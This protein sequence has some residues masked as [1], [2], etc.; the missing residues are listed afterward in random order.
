MDLWKYFD[1]THR[2][3][4]VCNPTSIGKLEQLVTLLN[5]PPKAQVLEFASGKA[6]FL[7][8]LAEQYDIVG[9]GIDLSPYCIADAKSKHRERIP[10]AQLSFLEMDGADYQPEKPESFDLV[11]CIGA[12]WIFGGH[13]GTVKAL[14]EMTVP[15][16]LI[17]VGE[18]YWRQEP[19]AD[20]LAAI[21]EKR[22]SYGTHFENVAVAE[23]RGLKLLYTLVSNQ[24]DWDRYEGLQ[25][26]AS[27]EWASLSPE[28]P[29]VK[30]LLKRV[31]KN[32]EVYLKWERETLGWAIY[33]FKKV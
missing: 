10:D 20:Y 22:D 21:D 4:V 16:G 28:D 12:S 2:K 15:G 18:P 17:I 3:H 9:T 27:E 33:V 6:E 29:D 31:Y 19:E 30:E 5:L 32:K 23:K 25:W 7:V 8:R 24:D 14:R 26:Y 11:V 13:Q 1:I